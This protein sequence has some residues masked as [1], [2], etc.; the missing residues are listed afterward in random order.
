M[1]CVCFSS[2]SEICIHFRYCAL[3]QGIKELNLS[4]LPD[5]FV[6]WQCN[7]R[8]QWVKYMWILAV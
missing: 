4:Y 6:A 3:Y 7:K 8:S 5:R 2:H 1:T